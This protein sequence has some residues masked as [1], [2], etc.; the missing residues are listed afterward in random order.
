MVVA[1][2]TGL[3]TL[4]E[5]RNEDDLRRALTAGA[6]IIGI[7]NRDLHTFIVDIGTTRRLVPLIP[8]GKIIVAES[9]IR[10]REDVIDLKKLGVNAVL[11][12]EALMSAGDAGAKVRELMGY[13]A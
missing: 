4:C 7:N 13:P 8:Q 5:T 11:V 6:E 12:G 3:E 9:G 1:R 2:E 10:T